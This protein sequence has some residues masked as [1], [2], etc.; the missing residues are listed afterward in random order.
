MINL[1]S[2]VFFS[3]LCIFKW[4]CFVMIRYEVITGQKHLDPYGWI[5]YPHADFTLML[6]SLTTILY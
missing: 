1:L 6:L 4:L 5:Q 3:S 2:G